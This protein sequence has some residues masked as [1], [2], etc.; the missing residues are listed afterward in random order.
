MVLET[1]E[2]GYLGLKINMSVISPIAEIPL[3]TAITL[4]LTCALIYGLKK[5]PYADKILG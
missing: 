5:I 1:I 2:Y 3:I 4:V